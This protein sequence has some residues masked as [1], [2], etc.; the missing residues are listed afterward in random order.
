MYILL[1]VLVVAGLALGA[2]FASRALAADPQQTAEP[3][4][5]SGEVPQRTISVNGSGKVTLDPDIA[6]INIGVHTED[7]DAQSAVSENTTQTQ[8]VVSALR[9][10]GI[11]ERDLRTSN[12]SIYPRQDYDRDGELLGITYIVD[13]TIQ[14]TIRDIATVGEILDAAVQAGAN[15]INSIQFTVEDTSAAYNQA[16][17]AAVASARSRAEALA[18]AAGVELGAVQSISA[19]V[20]GG[21]TPVYQDMRVAIEQA[22]GEVPISPGQTELTVEVNV[23]YV[24]E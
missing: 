1:F 4:P 17:E 19:Y 7:T 23:V 9:R 24:I 11:A 8:A 21:P 2:V 6:R 22:A 12:F 16:L 20:S 10:A 3:D 14:V 15:N 18:S 13:N 5:A